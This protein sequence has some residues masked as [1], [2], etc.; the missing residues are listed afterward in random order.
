MK[1]YQSAQRTPERIASP[2]SSTY[3]QRVLLCIR[4]KTDY[5]LPKRGSEHRRDVSKNPEVENKYKK[6]IEEHEKT[7]A[8]LKEQVRREFANF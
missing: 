2:I 7:I 6:I 5:P 1:E 8:S 4:I 3:L